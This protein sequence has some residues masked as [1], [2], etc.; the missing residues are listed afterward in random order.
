MRSTD[1][2][3]ASA[4]SHVAKA[5]DTIGKL[6]GRLNIAEMTSPPHTLPR[7]MAVAPATT[8][9][10]RAVSASAA[11]AGVTTRANSNSVPT[12]WVAMA[13]TSASNTRKAM[14][15][16]RT[17]TPRASATSGL[18][19]AN[20]SGRAMMTIATTSTTVIAPNTIS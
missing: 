20:N 5:S 15:K 13:T 14:A 8:T 10:G 3:R 19:D 6:G 1:R 9:T 7:A 2:L 17:G 18:I 12:T 4:A 11:A 16:A